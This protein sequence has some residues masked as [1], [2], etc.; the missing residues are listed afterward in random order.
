MARR[1]AHLVLGEAGAQQGLQ[2]DVE[3][4]GPV[5]MLPR[6]VAQVEQQRGIALGQRQELSEAAD[7]LVL[8]L[9][10]VGGGQGAGRPE[11]IRLAETRTHMAGCLTST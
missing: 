2:G 4:A 11:G 3:E 8:D 1:Q 9:P 6:R 5:G 10:V 7:G